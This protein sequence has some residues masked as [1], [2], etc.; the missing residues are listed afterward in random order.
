MSQATHDWSERSREVAALLARSALGDRAA[1]E[2]LYERTS[3][4]LFGARPAASMPRA[5]S[6]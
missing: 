5:A 4:H 1:F 2:R 6:R 3:G